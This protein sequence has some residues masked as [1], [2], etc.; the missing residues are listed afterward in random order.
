MLFI[1]SCLAALSVILGAFGAHA[2]HDKLQPKL[3]LTF[4]TAVRY[5]MYH[6]FAIAMCGICYHL[7]NHKKILLAF[8]FFIVGIILFSGSLYALCLLSLNYGDTFN[9]LGAV[10]PLGG[11]S[12]ISGWLLLAF[13]MYKK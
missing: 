4:E 1:A 12:F 11:L 9:F 13:S 8:K 10:T 5:Q 6:A 7:F 3:L 2:L